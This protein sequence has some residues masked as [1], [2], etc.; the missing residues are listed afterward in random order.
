M[1]RLDF[2]LF[3]CLILLPFLSFKTRFFF[4]VVILFEFKR[5]PSVDAAY[6]QMINVQ[7]ALVTAVQNKNML[8]KLM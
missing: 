4:L 8:K 1:F 7:A 5:W 6:L 2:Y 3:I